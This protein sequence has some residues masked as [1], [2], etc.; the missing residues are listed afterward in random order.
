MDGRN[1]KELESIPFLGQYIANAVELMI[2]GEPS[3]LIDV[4]MSRLLERYFGERKMADIRYDNYLQKLSY[5]IVNQKN[6][7]AINWAILD[8]AAIVCKAQ[9]PLCNDCLLKAKCTYFKIKQKC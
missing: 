5:K 6:S 9:K 7:K 8:Y 3:P 4:N 1:R 2:F